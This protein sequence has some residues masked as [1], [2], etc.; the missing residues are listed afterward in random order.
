MVWRLKTWQI[1]RCLGT[2]RGSVGLCSKDFG[3]SGVEEI[4]MVL[5]FV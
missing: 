2:R 5:E 4:S 1:R 3:D